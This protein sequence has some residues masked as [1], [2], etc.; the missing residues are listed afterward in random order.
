MAKGIKTRRGESRGSNGTYLYN[1]G[2]ISPIA[3]DFTIV[4]YAG[5]SVTLTKNPSNMYCNINGGGSTSGGHLRCFTTNKVDLTSYSKLKVECDA[6]VLDNYSGSS[7]SSFGFSAHAVR[8]YDSA[9]IAFKNIAVSSTVGTV[10]T[11]SGIFEVDISGVSG[12]Y[13]IAFGGY[14]EPVTT[15]Y[16][17]GTIYKV[18]LE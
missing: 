16:S 9:N 17:R 11:A 8:T 12:S 4:S 5:S 6:S 1:S 13:Y 3:G 10:A 2:D 14:A 15:S 18:W 7:S